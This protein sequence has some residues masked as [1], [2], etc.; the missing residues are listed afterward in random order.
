MTD[1]VIKKAVAVCAH[2]CMLKVTEN[3]ECR[4][5][6]QQPERHGEHTAVLCIC[7]TCMCTRAHVY[8][9]M[10]SPENRSS[11]VPW[12][13]LTWFWDR[14]SLVCLLTSRG[15]LASGPGS[16]CLCLPTAGLTVSSSHCLASSCGFWGPS[17][18][19][20]AW[21]AQQALYGLSYLHGLLHSWVSTCL[22][23][24]IKSMLDLCLMWGLMPSEECEQEV[25]SG[26]VGEHP[27]RR[28]AWAWARGFQT[29]NREGE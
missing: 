2:V 13:L 21:L 25:R 12:V 22:R 14:L 18:G 20:H 19:P 6:Q 27:H 29:G 1:S 24:S 15:W 26:W 28:R 7:C 17:S 11:A 5:Q 9:C 23:K 4:S 8:T 16:C 3:V 10:F